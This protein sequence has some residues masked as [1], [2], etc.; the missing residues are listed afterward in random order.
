MKNLQNVL[1]DLQ[2]HLKWVL[3]KKGRDESHLACPEEVFSIFRV[4]AMNTDNVFIVC[5]NDLWRGRG[6]GREFM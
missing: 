5:K 1:I 6:E 3:V 4:L 2:S